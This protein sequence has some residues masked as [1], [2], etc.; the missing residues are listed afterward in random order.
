[1][2][3]DYLFVGLPRAGGLHSLLLARFA[4]F[5]RVRSPRLRVRSLGLL[6]AGVVG[7]QEGVGGLGGLDLHRYCGQIDVVPPAWLQMQA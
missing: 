1:M 2:I 6:V 3:L 5:A 7:G 4:A